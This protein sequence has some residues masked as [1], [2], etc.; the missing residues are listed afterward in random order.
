MTSRAVISVYRP[1]VYVALR[2]PWTTALIGVF[3]IVSAVP[4]AARLGHEFMPP[5]DEG[6]VLYMPMTLSGVSIEQA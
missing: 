4:L 3:A 6:D 5:L 2:R 1:F